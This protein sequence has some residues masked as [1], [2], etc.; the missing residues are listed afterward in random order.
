MR[1]RRPRRPREPPQSLLPVPQMRRCHR[2]VPSVTACRVTSCRRA[3]PRSRLF[4]VERHCIARD[5]E[6][7][8][9]HRAA[10]PHPASAASTTTRCLPPA[11]P[12]PAPDAASSPT[13]PLAAP[14]TLSTHEAPP[15]ESPREYART[16]GLPGMSGPLILWSAVHFRREPECPWPGRPGAAPWPSL[17]GGA[18]IPP[19]RWRS[20]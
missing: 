5:A 11:D 19:P 6:V 3:R 13:A 18:P 14:S 2:K 16:A 12:E 15:R 4:R 8:A 17:S 9:C 1:P 7:S 20:P 10:A